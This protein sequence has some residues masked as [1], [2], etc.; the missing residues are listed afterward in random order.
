MRHL[1]QYLL[2]ISSLTSLSAEETTWLHQKDFVD[3]SYIITQPGTYRLAE[4]ISFNPNSVNHLG[5]D[6]YRSGFP[7][8][9]QYTHNGG[10]YDPMAFG[11]GFFA[12]IVITADD[13]ILDLNGHRIEQSQEH[14]LLQRFFAVIELASAPFIPK[15]GPHNF[16]AEVQSSRNVRILN[17]N[18]GRSAHHGIHGNGNYKIHIENVNF[19]DFEVAAVALNGVRDLTIKNCNAASRTDVPVLGT[20]SSARFLQ[21]YLEHLVRTGSSTHLLVGGQRMVTALSAQERLR[22]AINAVYQDLI[23]EG[24]DHIDAKKHPEEYALFHNKHAVVDGNCYGFLVNAMGQA[25]NGFSESETVP[26]DDYAMNIHLENV[27]ISRL[28]GDVREIIALKRNNNA[29]IDPVGAV[30]QLKNRHPE[31]KKLITISHED[32]RQAVYLGNVVA[33]AQALIAKAHLNGDFAKSHLDLSRLSIDADVL[34]WIEAPSQNPESKLSEITIAPG[35]YFCNADSM[36]H[37]NKGVIGFRI[38]AATHVK[39][40]NT[41][42]QSVQ[43]IGEICSGICG[44]YQK[45]HPK[46]TLEGCGGPM[47]RG[48]CL[49]GSKDVTIEMGHVGQLV[50]RCG[51][52]IAFD[53]LTDCDS[54]TLNR[55]SVTGITAGPDYHKNESPQSS[56]HAIGFHVDKGAKNTSLHRIVVSDLQSTHH[57]H[58]VL[59]ESNPYHTD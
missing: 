5:K 16:G 55:C 31:T 43:N 57:S 19:E 2:V 48:Y 47:A 40:I 8:S 20:F 24:R 56:P 4:D 26:K 11:I 34:G 33:D 7:L 13:V 29:V 52:A 27:H 32:D 10:K 28:H 41:S 58:T 6:A 1:L 44:G 12:S 51:S 9:S 3:G 25:I 23:A 45:S 35:G 30:F 53:I 49:A 39:L 37:V 18:I 54:V 46:A 38:D 22:K 17:G 15:Q 42:A 14:A 36:F 59:D 50:S 21:P